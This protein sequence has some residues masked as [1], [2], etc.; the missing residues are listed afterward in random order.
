MDKVAA[1]GNPFI[2]YP[3][4]SSGGT[5]AGV[6]AALTGRSFSP[7]PDLA[8]LGRWPQLL[9]RTPDGMRRLV[10][11]QMDERH[12]LPP[13]L[14]QSLRSHHLATWN[15]AHYA[16]LEPDRQFEAIVLGA[17]SGATAYLCACLGVPFLS[18]TFL[19][20]LRQPADPDNIFEYHTAGEKLASPLLANNAD[21]HVISHYDPIHER[22]ALSRGHQLRLK[23]L[24]LPPA[25]RDFIQ[26]RLAPGGILLILNCIQEWPQYRV[27]ERH[28][29]QVGGLGG[30][31]HQDYESGRVRLKA[32]LES[33]GSQHESGWRLPLPIHPAPESEWGVLPAFVDSIHAYGNESGVRVRAITLEQ[34]Q[35]LSTL[36]FFAWQ[37]LY[38]ITELQPTGI[39]LS[40][41]TQI[42]PS[43]PLAC[44][45]LPLWLPT[46]GTDSRDFLLAMRPDLP[47]VLPL[48]FQP[49]STTPPALDTPDSAAWNQTL[50]GHIGR[51]LG[52]PQE[53]YP[54]AA[55]TSVTA[56]AALRRWTEHF[57]A[58]LPRHLKMA[59]FWRLFGETD[60]LAG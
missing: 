49:W 41:Y 24:D 19:A 14:T 42:D 48:L 7:R 57:A 1:D 55:L 11:K 36:A 39:L 40:G 25:Y 5:V 56:A 4:S 38:E 20:R 21:L 45:L 26:Q 53:D 44:P 46:G 51:W 8:W 58:P 2:D 50:R 33:L 6:A 23:L 30:L 12:L 59:E 22:Q 17:P 27:A 34:I 9:H 15:L 35:D 31:R 3:D 32:W 37:W 16:G 13:T 29:L 43:A 52:I 10:Q 28:S 18:H 47:D 60:E 54:G